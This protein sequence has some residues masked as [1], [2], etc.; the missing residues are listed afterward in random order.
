MEPEPEAVPEPETLL[1]P[2]ALTE[3]KREP[4][5]EPEAEAPHPPAVENRE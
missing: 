3:A 4:A 5:I 2:E 1:E